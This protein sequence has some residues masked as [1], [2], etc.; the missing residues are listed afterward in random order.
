MDYDV[1]GIPEGYDR[2]R[3]LSPDTLKL[4]MDTVAPWVTSTPR[5]ILDLGAGTGRFSDPLAVRFAATV[6]AV[7]PSA[8]M[9][10][11]AVGKHSHGAVHLVRGQGRQSHCKTIRLISSSRR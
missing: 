7:D 5:T 10:A 9:L 3:G 6:I 8:K 11:Q 1:T 4:W 2:G